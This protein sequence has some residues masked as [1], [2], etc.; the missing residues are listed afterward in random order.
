VYRSYVDDTPR[1]EGAT[2]RRSLFLA[3]LA[4]LLVLLAAIPAAAGGWATV[5]LDSTPAGVVPGKAWDVNITVLQ[6]GRTPLADVTPIVTIQS[7]TVT[8]EFAATPTKRAG[9]YAA[10]VVFPSAGRWTY[11]VDDGFM[12]QV[13]TYPPITIAGPPAAA[14]AAAAKR[15]GGGIAS[16]WLW[17]AGGALLLALAIVA[18]DRRRRAQPA[19]LPRAPEPAA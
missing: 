16:G 1:A 15:D 9:V 4:L 7:G 11:Q 6:H 2:V 18:L 10:A 8:R 17:G 3:P 13:H 5:G 14:A 19:V 12:G